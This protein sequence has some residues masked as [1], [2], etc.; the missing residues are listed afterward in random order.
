MQSANQ[1]N[2]TNP[3]GQPV[4]LKTEKILNFSGYV[5]VEKNGIEIK[6]KLLNSTMVSQIV[7]VKKIYKDPEK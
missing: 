4:L 2:K 3:S 1:G 6:N 5:K 7:I